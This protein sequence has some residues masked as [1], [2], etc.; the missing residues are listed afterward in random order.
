MNNDVNDSVE[1]HALNDEFESCTEWE[2]FCDEAYF[3]CWAVRPVGEARWGHCFHMVS[4]QEAES[5]TELLNRKDGREK[6]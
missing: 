6:E 4:Q 2:C 3:G 1:N 5:L